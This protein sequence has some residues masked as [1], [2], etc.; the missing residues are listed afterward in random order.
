MTLSCISQHTT[1]ETTRTTMAKSTKSSKPKTATVPMKQIKA[2]V[3]QLERNNKLLEL[4]L[5]DDHQRRFVEGQ[6][7]SN[8]KQISLWLVTL[9]RSQDLR[10][11][12]NRKKDRGNIS[13]GK[14]KQIDYN[15]E[16]SLSTAH[17]SV[18]R[19]SKNSRRKTRKNIEKL[20][21][22]LEKAFQG[23]GH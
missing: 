16:G 23:F 12:I 19:I 6:I 13:V 4:S 2:L 1:A 14:V 9:D 22:T 21:S 7:I 8:K 17:T 3:K 15:I 18:K 10:E 5:Q 20:T 11:K